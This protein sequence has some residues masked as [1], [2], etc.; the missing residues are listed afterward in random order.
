MFLCYIYYNYT[1]TML[2]CIYMYIYV[3]LCF[4]VTVI[5]KDSKSLTPVMVCCEAGHDASRKIDSL[6]VT[7]NKNLLQVSI[8]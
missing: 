4:Y 2:L 3:L 7:M 1:I 5:E 8:V 6:A